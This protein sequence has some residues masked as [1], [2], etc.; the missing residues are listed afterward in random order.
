M[1]RNGES[2]ASEDIFWVPAVF[3]FLNNR[4]P[5]WSSTWLSH[6]PAS[7]PQSLTPTVLPQILVWH[8]EFP[9]NPA[10]NGNEME[11]LLLRWCR[12][13]RFPIR[14]ISGMMKQSFASRF[15]VKTAPAALTMTHWRSYN[16]PDW[17]IGQL[18]GLNE[19]HDLIGYTWMPTK[20]TFL[21]TD[22]FDISSQFVVRE[23]S[24]VNQTISSLPLISCNRF[25][26]N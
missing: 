16:K 25:Q 12:I 22:S 24:P 23:T 1:N 11:L 5:G 26:R 2:L 20:I 10:S 7:S 6:W 21:S 15:W 17:V 4:S 19:P 9:F 14:S 13:N 3:S 8:V 18:W